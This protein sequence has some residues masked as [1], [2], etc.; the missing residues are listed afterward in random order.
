MA[1][2]VAVLWG[3]EQA[4]PSLGF[5]FLVVLPGSL[6]SEFPEKLVT[7]QIPGRHLDL[8]SRWGGAWEFAR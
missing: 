5:G 8:D 7:M 2:A 1:V 6:A 3:S 4:F